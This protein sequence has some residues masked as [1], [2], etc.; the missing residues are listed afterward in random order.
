[1]KQLLIVKEY[2]PITY[3]KEFIRDKYYKYLEHEQ[4]VELENLILT[5][6]T[7]EESDA[8]DFFSISSHRNVG[9]IIS[10]KNFVGIVQMKKGCQI[11]ILPKIANS[12]DDDKTKRMF[13]KMLRSM[14]DFPGK[15]FNYSNLKVDQMNLYEVF[16]SMY[17][18]EVRHLVKRG[19]KSA[20]RAVEENTVFY[21]GKLIFNE[22]IRNNS[23][24]KERFYVRYDDFNVD[25]AENRL[26]KATLI[27]LIGI[28]E[29]SENIKEMW[30]LLSGFEMVKASTNYIKDFSK[31]V[32]DRNTKDYEDLIMW[33]KVFLLNKSF[34]TFSGDTTSRA[35][36]FPMERVFEAYVGRN[37]RRHL[38]DT[39]WEVSLQDSGYYLFDNIFALRPD[40]VLRNFSEDRIIILDTK[41]KILKSD[42]D[43]NYGISQSDMY[44]MYAYAKKYDSKEIWLLYPQN[45]DVTDFGNIIFNSDS[46]ITLKVFFIDVEKIEDSLDKLLMQIG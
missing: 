37:I 11:Q 44:Q 35:L 38:M 9:K 41:W 6:N 45:D 8:I 22:Q 21:K 26:I 19:L 24:H 12:E 39:N 15:S 5:Y 20:Y 27:K 4:F 28:S 32:L 34:T 25:R 14:K 29:S 17:I 7:V 23:A 42:P 13:L 43:A 3:N 40:I 16:I 2:D 33:S 1:M 31:V 46:G 18:R 36:L 30:Q 10:A